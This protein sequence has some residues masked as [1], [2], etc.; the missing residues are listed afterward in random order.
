MLT[1]GEGCREAITKQEIRTER[2][3]TDYI[4]DKD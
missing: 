1:N 3:V 4:N 2:Q